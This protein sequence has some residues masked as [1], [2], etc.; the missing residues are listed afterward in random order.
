MKKMNIFKS[1]ALVFGLAV[2][3]SCGDAFL[4]TTSLTRIFDENFYK[5]VADAEMALIGCYDGYQDISSSGTS[6]YIDTELLSDECY[7]GG[8]NTDGRGNQLIDRFD[9]GQNPSGTNTFEGEWNNSYAAI[10]R[11][12][13]L[14]QKL[15]GLELGEDTTTKG[16]IEGEARFLRAILYFDMVRLGLGLY[17]FGAEGLQPVSTLRTRVVQVRDLAAGEAVGYGCEGIVSRASRVATIS[18]GYADG[19]RR[20]LGNG[21]WKMKVRG[22]EVPTLGRISMDTCALDVTD[23]DVYVGDEVVVFGPHATAEDM[24]SVL[25]TIPY[26]VMTGI[27]PRVKRVY[28]KE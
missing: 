12:N 22:V 3:T 17:G 28:I 10:Y 2:L 16:R 5:T 25:G 11:C 13:V 6:F 27:A 19:M 24:A 1:G 7:G 21:R 15:A 8:G 14:I 20:H 9:I 18:T 26:E 23:V 4:D